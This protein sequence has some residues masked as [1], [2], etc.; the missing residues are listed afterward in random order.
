MSTQHASPLPRWLIPVLA[1]SALLLVIVIALGI[2]GGP[3]KVA[4]GTMDTQAPP[5]PA[6]A[7][8][9]TV[10]QQAAANPQAWQGTVR[11]RSLARLAPKLTARILEVRVH[12]GDRVKAGS[13]IAR[14]DDRDL[15]AAYQAA[16]AALLAAQ[17]QATQANAEERRSSDLLEKQAAT[18]QSHE[19]VVAQAQAAR[20]GVAQAASH[21]QQAKVMLDENGLR[22]AFDGIIGE[23]L[24]EPGELGSPNQAI[25]TLYRPEDLRL[26]AAIASHCLQHLEVGLPVKLHLEGIANEID[27]KIDEITPEIDPQ[28]H[29]Q[30]L[31]VQLPAIGIRH[32]QFGWLTLSCQAEHQAL[33]IPVKAVLHYGQLQAVKVV[34]KGHVQTRHIRT[35][36][37]HGDRIEVL[38]GLHD[39]E[40]ILADSELVL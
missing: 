15:T 12:P 38:S 16:T 25:V 18:R 14:L 28:T 23:R 8:T 6:Q 37:R 36:K 13:L 31:K 3:D 39:G 24:Q 32:G 17:A 11:S 5:L 7:E 19:A 34:A 10:H 2:I 27:G 22:A 20:A 4:P 40:T 21:V 26:E 33:L 35:G 1:L 29:T 30:W 9:F